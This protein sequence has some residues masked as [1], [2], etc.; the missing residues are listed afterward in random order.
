M[1]IRDLANLEDR[2]D[3]YYHDYAY[4][5]TSFHLCDS[6]ADKKNDATQA[7]SPGMLMAVEAEDDVI[8]CFSRD[9]LDPNLSRAWKRRASTLSLLMSLRPIQSVL[10]TSHWK[11]N[12]SLPGQWQNPS[13]LGLIFSFG[14][15]STNMRVRRTFLLPPLE[16]MDRLYIRIVPLLVLCLELIHG[17]RR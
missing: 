17:K 4:N 14:V 7:R 10:H 5:A 13:T 12:V 8:G 9:N 16:E 2:F 15:Q 6:L 3:F 11:K 1:V